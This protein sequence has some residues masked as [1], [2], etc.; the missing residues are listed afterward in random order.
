MLLPRLPRLLFRRTLATATMSTT[1]LEDAIRSK[2]TA[3]LAPRTLE[4]WN[5]SHKHA[6]HS[7]MR[8]VADKKETHF[9]VVVSS[10]QFK[11][12]PQIARHRA[13]NALLK[14]ELEREGG[15]H[16]LQMRTLTLEEEDRLLEKARE[17]EKA[18]AEAE[19]NCAG[20]CAK[21]GEKA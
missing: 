12:Q 2:L 18:E 8:G 16:A 7:A 21:G 3:S 19:G 4:I 10:A 6:H 14:E 20:A 13:V 11:G 15:I 17:M 9:R 1:P 5:D